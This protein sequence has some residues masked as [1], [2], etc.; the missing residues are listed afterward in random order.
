MRI[1]GAGGIGRRDILLHPQARAALA[2]YLASGTRFQTSA[3]PFTSQREKLPVPSGELDGWRLGEAAIHEWWKSVKAD[4]SEVEW[5]SVREVTFL[6]LRHDFAQRAEEAGWPR[7]ELAGYLGHTLR[8]GRSA[9]RQ[10]RAE[11]PPLGDLERIQLIK[12]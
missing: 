10:V 12:G 6:D 9:G 8:R 11:T 5:A 2:T 1:R 7:E 3:Y 4:A